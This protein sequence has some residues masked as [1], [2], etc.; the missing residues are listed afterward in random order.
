MIW[1]MHECDH[2]LETLTRP[3]FILPTATFKGMI[4]MPEGE[5]PPRESLGINWTDGARLEP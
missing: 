4:Q 5:L 1:M 3:N 2:R